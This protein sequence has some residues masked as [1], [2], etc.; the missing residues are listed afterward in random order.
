MPLH[1]AVGPLMRPGE[2]GVVPGE[3]ARVRMGDVPQLFT[4]ATVIV[5]AAVPTVVVMLVPE[6]VPLQ[7]AGKVQE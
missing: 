5:P 6:E 2:G 4:A 3:T 7:P 1:G